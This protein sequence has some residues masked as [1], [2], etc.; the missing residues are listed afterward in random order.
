MLKGAMIHQTFVEY[1]KPTRACA[2]VQ[3][4]PLAFWHVVVT[5]CRLLFGR[6]FTESH[7]LH[8]AKYHENEN[9]DYIEK[10]SV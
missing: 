5:N 1:H 3:F 7:M 10:I 4:Q 2:G 8:I 9:D 6:T